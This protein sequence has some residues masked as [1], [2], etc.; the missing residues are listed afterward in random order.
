MAKNENQ[1]VLY[2]TT[3]GATTLEVRVQSESVWLSAHQMAELFQV[4][5]SGIVRHIQNVYR[6]KEL[7]RAATC[8]K[9]AQ[10]AADGKTRQMDLYNLDVIISVGYRV[11][12]KRGT[13]FRIWA[14]KVLK[15]YLIKGYALN[16]DRLRQ[17]NEKIKELEKTVAMLADIVD[18]KPLSSD[19]ATGLLRV[20]A[21]YTFAL[22]LLDRYDHQSLKI[23]DTSGKGV[24]RIS[25][26]GARK[27]IEELGRK[28]GTLG[29]FGHE[30][31]ESFKSSL[32]TIYQTFGGQ[33]LYPSV[34]EKAA[35]L[36]YFIVKNHSFIDGNKRIAAFLFLWFLEENGILYKPDGGRRLTDNALV[37]LTLMIAESK[38]N[39][40]EIILTAIFA[41][42]LSFII[43]D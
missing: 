3:D 4:D 27:A 9:N 22:D 16:D 37:A 25:Y 18:R 39:E 17:H 21:D 19:E 42:G 33:E 24:F 12:S 7:P 40:R 5:R 41:K 36:L 31:D 29:L 20:I 26:K 30:K 32:N 28:T 15:D 43:L 6:T 38:P 13:Q 35:N 23:E 34:E 10:V 14:S 8:A 11:N 1:I 2:R